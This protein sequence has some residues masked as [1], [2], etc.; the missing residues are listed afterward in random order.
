MRIGIFGSGGD[1]QCQ[2]VKALLEQRGAEVVLVESQ[3]LNQG[4]A[5]WFDGEDYWAGGRRLSDGGGW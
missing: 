1:P 5:F 3:G 2:A 4:Q